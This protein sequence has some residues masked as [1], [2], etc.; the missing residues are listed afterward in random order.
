[1]GRTGVRAVPECWAYKVRC[2]SDGLDYLTLSDNMA[3]GHECRYDCDTV[4]ILTWGDS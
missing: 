4:T 2:D 3:E 1:M